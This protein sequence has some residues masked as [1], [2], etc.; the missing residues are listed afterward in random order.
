MKNL[1]NGGAFALPVLLAVVP[2]AANA[3]A[4]SQGIVAIGQRA[5][6]H[7]PAGTMGEHVHKGGEFM[8]GL[9]WL[10]DDYRGANRTGTRK[11][12]DQ[13]VAMAGYSVRTK[14]MTMDM[15][16][17]H[18]M[19]APNDRVTL[20]AMPMWMRMDMTML[21]VGAHGE[22]GDHGG[23]MAAMA[24][25]DHSSHTLAPGQ[26]MSHSVSGFGDTEVGA[27]VSLSRK[28]SLSA[29]T[30]LS[31]S[32]PTGSVSRKNHNGQFVHYMMQGGSGTWD[33]IPSFT[34]SGGGEALRW[35][36]QARYRFRA[37]DRNKSGFRFGDRFDANL[38]LAKPL[39][40]AAA[41]TARLAYL[42]EG[43]IEG[44]YNGPH[45]HASPPDLQQNYGGQVI[46]AG[47]GANVVIGGNLRLGA[48]AT[49]PLYQDLNGIQSP[50]R[51]GVN[52]NLSRMF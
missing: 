38:W 8:V 49:V 37:E 5:D 15:A 35:G 39:S 13:Q 9:I 17:L 31:V 3:Q 28:P 19:W 18:L 21:G 45:G 40:P 44:H 6:E 20:M 50:R 25:D 2:A 46:Q 47:L 33:L 12:T 1:K 23:E 29:H 48:E 4:S 24:M 22:H 32:I 16:M 52:V 41:I 30:G 36:A 14:S 51:F 11:L 43:K 27:L 34:V 26:T 10:H 42:D 7:G